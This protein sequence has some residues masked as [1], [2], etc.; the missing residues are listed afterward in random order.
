MKYVTSFSAKGYEQ[1]GQRF[2]QTY[3]EHM[4]HPI[5]V[6]VEAA[7]DF[8]H[9][10]VTYK[11]LF[12][13]PGCQEFLSK[14]VFDIMH[15]KMWD[16]KYDYRFA[17]SRFCR[18]HF[19]LLD[20]AE[21]EAMNGGDWLVW[22]DADIELG[23]SI[24]DPVDG[25]FMY[26]L[27]RPEWHSCTSYVAWDVRKSCN[28]DWWYNLKNLYMTGSV[29]V[30]PEWHDCFIN[31]WLRDNMKVDAI[32][33]AAPYA[34]QLKGPANVFDFVFQQSHHKKGA[35]KHTEATSNQIK[36]SVVKASVGKVGSKPAAVTGVIKKSGATQYQ[37][38]W[39]R[40]KSVASG[41]RTCGDRY[42]MIAPFFSNY[43]RR[44]SVFDL[45]ANLGYFSFRI[46]EDFD[47]VCT[48]ADNRPQLIDLCKANNSN[49]NWLN[50]RLNAH[51]LARLAE[52]EQFDVVLALA[53]LHH[54]RQDWKIAFEAV[55]ALGQWVIVEIPA[56]AD[57]DTLNPE[58]HAELYDHIL[59][60]G[61][62]IGYIPSHTSGEPRPIVLVKGHAPRISKKYLGSQAKDPIMDLHLDFD[63]AEIQ[64]RHLDA[65][66]KTEVRD[67]V[68]GINLWSFHKLNGTYP[69]RIDETFVAC[70]ASMSAKHDDLRLWNYILSGRELQPIDVGNKAFN[71]DPN[72][73]ALQD[74]IDLLKGRVSAK[75]AT[76]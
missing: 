16:G 67:Y 30:M 36:A 65:S 1:Y 10:L 8:R 22:L 13:V 44:F 28:A 66:Q 24:P 20:A 74:C 9:P 63:K 71:N 12:N 31:D 70:N 29:F 68:P 14:M 15:G 27:G 17:I 75:V 23:E 60:E 45:G 5:V 57:G 39:I 7:C 59:S 11:P 49:V 41:Q 34:A 58:I 38:S 73:T 37:E 4:H 46:A 51:D 3:V 47:A 18:K 64:I 33:L 42:D 52:C 62:L 50:T 76:G 54:F 55:R 61:K 26:Y 19:A 69:E 25:P 6:Y 48:M 56:R 53:V 21:H 72:D 40:G 32:N 43:K 35:L 2:L